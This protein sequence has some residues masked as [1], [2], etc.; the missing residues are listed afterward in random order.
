MKHL[1]SQFLYNPEGVGLHC[2]ASA[3]HEMPDGGLIAAWYAYSE[4]EHLD[5]KL[6]LARRP[7]GE[8][9]WRKSVIPFPDLSYS[10]GNP[11]LFTDGAGRLHLLFVLIKGLYWNDAVLYG[12]RSADSG[13]TWSKPRM[14]RSETG[15]MVRHAP[16]RLRN[17]GYLL[18]AYDENHGQTVLLRASPDAETWDMVHRIADPPLIQATLVRQPD[19]RLVMFFRPTTEPRRIWRSTSVDDGRSWSV[20]VR[21]PLPNPLSGIAAFSV[22]GTTAVVYN[23]TR[24]HQRHPL[25][26]A[27]SA[28]G[29]V[30]WSEPWH[31]DTIS[32]EVSYP[33]FITGRDGSVHGV[34]TYNRRM[35]KYVSLQLDGPA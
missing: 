27:R 1:G 26:M 21:T 31:I 7:V 13:V 16:I 30:T 32:K 17:G 11:V 19:E 4:K 33:C 6:I 2:H 28:D 15:L 9:Y 3:L 8:A 29:G 22:N 14:L 10:A 12:S 18:P 35:I 23:H 20:P 5:A 25:S 34:Y 24:E